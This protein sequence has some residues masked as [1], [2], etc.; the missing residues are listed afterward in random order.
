MGKFLAVLHVLE[1]GLQNQ[2]SGGNKNVLLSSGLQCKGTSP[3]LQEKRGGLPTM[4]PDRLALP[5]VKCGH[6]VH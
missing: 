6:G 2:S 4:M 3:F 1:Q 5:P